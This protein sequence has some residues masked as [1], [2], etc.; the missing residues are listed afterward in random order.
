[1]SKLKKVVCRAIPDSVTVRTPLGDA[2]W[3]GIRERLQCP[4]NEQK[5][6]CFAVNNH[7]RVCI[8]KEAV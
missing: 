4:V 2:T 1:M 5:Q 3:N 6:T 8:V 7:L